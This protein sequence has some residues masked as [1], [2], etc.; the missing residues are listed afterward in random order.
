MIGAFLG[1]RLMVLTLV[2][3]SLLGSNVGLSLMAARRGSMKSA[4]PF[5]TFLTIA[6]FVSMVAGSRIVSWYL[7]FF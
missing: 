6:A 4:L 7:A 2:V 3:A 5:G 1:W